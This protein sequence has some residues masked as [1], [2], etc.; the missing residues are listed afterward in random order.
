M[1]M[2][3][4]NSSEVSGGSRRRRNRN[5]N[6]MKRKRRARNSNKNRKGGEGPGLLNRITDEFKETIGKK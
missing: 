1:Y 3:P 2:R 5:K 4:L 6:T